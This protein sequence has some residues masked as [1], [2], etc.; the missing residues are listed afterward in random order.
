MKDW[1]L[2]LN[3]REQKLVASLGGVFIIFLSYSLI[4]Q[5]LNNNIEQEQKKL[6]RRQELLSF[7]NDETYRYK[8]LGGKDVRQSSGSL[9]SVVNRTARTQ[10]ISI[11]RVQPQNA[12]IQ[13]WIDAVPFERLVSWLETLSNNEG[14]QVRN[15]D[16][17]KTDL[18]G[19]VRIK[20]LQLGKN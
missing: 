13:V 14:I 15:I 17:A 4:W 1:W 5:P 11:S 18:A 10:G 16:L 6:E 9:S 8:A 19:Q 12:D 7:V 3:I 20:R 2:Q